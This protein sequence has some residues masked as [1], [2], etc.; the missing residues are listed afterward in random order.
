[1]KKILCLI[2][3]TFFAVLAY[4]QLEKGSIFL[5][6]TTDLWGGI[7]YSNLF[8]GPANHGGIA[9]VKSKY[10]SDEETEDGPEMNAFNLSPRIGYAFADGFVAGVKAGI[11]SM[12]IKDEYDGEENKNTYTVIGAGPFARYYIPMESTI[13]PFVEGEAT[14]GTFKQKYDEG[15]EYTSNTMHLGGGAGI[16]VLLGEKVT[17][18]MMAGYFYNTIK[19]TKSDSDSKEII[20]GFG[21]GLGFTIFL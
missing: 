19:N 6:S 12:T 15:D 9:I 20:S 4:S 1:M 13:R 16:A 8:C 18:D 11:S 14:F 3:F 5:G 10:K 17:F 7:S 2:A 21:L